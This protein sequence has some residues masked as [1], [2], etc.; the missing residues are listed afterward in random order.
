MEH[1]LSVELFA[2]LAVVLLAVGLATAYYEGLLYPRGT[3]STSASNGGLSVNVSDATLLITACSTNATS[4]NCSAG[5][6]LGKLTFSVE[7]IG[8]VEIVNISIRFNG[9]PWNGSLFSS[10][11]VTVLNPL[12]P[13]M[14]ANFVSQGIISSCAYGNNMLT[15]LATGNNNQVSQATTAVKTVGSCSV[16]VQP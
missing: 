12:D 6:N 5:S 1:K 14:S 15:V 10:P 8:K 11:S 3:G 7:N 4:P 16:T 2:V 9:G 13:G